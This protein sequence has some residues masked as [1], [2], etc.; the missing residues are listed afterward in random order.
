ML[1]GLVRAESEWKIGVMKDEQ[2]LAISE[3]STKNAMNR[4][5][6]NVQQ[7]QYDAAIGRNE[8]DQSIMSA[9]R[10]YNSDNLRIA[11]DMFGANLKADAQRRSMPGE[12]IATPKPLALPRPDI[13]DP[14]KPGDPPEPIKGAK[15]GG[16]NTL[17]ALSGAANNLAGL[18]WGAITNKP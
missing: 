3:F 7:A 16:I 5:D 12:R 6:T 13:Q 11:N 10:S 14:Y 4:I 18:D 17:N 15:S 8:I 2:A 9:Q 1:D